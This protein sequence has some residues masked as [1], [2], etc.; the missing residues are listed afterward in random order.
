MDCFCFDSIL[1]V[2]L[3]WSPQFIKA[4]KLDSSLKMKLAGILF[5]FSVLDLLYL[6]EAIV[7][8]TECC[9]KAVS[10]C[11]LSSF[12]GVEKGWG[13][14]VS[15]WNSSPFPL[16]SLPLESQITI[17]KVFVSRSTSSWQ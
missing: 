8:A 11:V 17:T 12:V 5:V 3:G 9:K 14:G 4:F 16:P 6:D 10:N 7:S 15:L 1:S 2:A 13:L